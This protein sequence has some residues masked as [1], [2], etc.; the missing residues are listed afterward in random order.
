MITL[1]YAGLCTLLILCL[2]GRV[3]ARRMQAKIGLGD[4]GDGE[5]ARRIRAHANAVEYLPLA[6]LLLGGMELNGYPDPAIHAFGATLLASR[7]L[8]AWGLS[9]SSGKSVG[10]FAGTALT[11]VLMLAMALF[12]IAGHLSGYATGEP[13]EA[14]AY[15][16]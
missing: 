6:L 4:G 14:A 9:R 11:L 13:A 16:E 12:A 15:E 5:L 3:M 2:A 10:R 7:I 1:F 8:H